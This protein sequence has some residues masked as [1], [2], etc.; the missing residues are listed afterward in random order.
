MV[1]SYVISFMNKAVNIQR[2]LPKSI[3]AENFERV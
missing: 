3:F 2:F 1:L